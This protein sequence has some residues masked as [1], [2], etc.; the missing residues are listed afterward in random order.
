MCE[1]SEKRPTCEAKSPKFAKGC[2]GWGW[3]GSRA[4]L[5][6]GPSVAPWPSVAR[7]V[8]YVLN[9]KVL[10]KNYR[11]LSFR[12]V[13]ARGDTSNFA[14]DFSPLGNVLPT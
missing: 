8:A 12:P 4:W 7:W 10:G 6:V 1:V 14:C 11:A 9:C 13:R 5:S 2:A 3:S